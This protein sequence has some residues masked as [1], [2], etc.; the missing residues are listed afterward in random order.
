MLN[1]I[2][3]IRKRIKAKR[4]GWIFAAN[5]F[6]DIGS[7]AAV[8]QAL[9]RLTRSGTIRRIGTGLYDYPRINPRI[10][11]VAPDIHA[12]ARKI[13][14]KRGQ[15]IQISGAHA[16]NAL[17]LSTQVPARRIYLTDGSYMTK[18]VGGQTI[19]FRHAAPRNML[20]A[21]TTA[22]TV[23]QALR[24]LGP[25]GVDDRVVKKLRRN[26]DPKTK[27]DLTQNLVRMPGWMMDSIHSVIEAI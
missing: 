26:L 16:A 9:G 24:Y 3:S 4:R 10:G 2:G 8:D 13:A 12:I 19:Q 15:T 17:G 6:L 1:I 20:G 14:N 11:Q 5:D 23:Y 18:K 25:K 27:S 7:R 21:G 22:G